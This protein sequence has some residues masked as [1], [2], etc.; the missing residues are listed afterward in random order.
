MAKNIVICV[1]GTNGTFGSRNTNVVRLYSLLAQD[2][3][4]QVCFYDPGI[5]TMAAPGALTQFTQQLTKLLG[6]AIAYGVTDRIADAYRHLMECYEPGDRVYLFGFSRGAYIVRALAG[7]LHMCGLLR[8]ANGTLVQSAIDLFSKHDDETFRVAKEFRATFCRECPVHFVGVWDTVSSVGWIYDPISFPYTANNPSVAIGRHAISIDERRCYFR[9]NLWGPASEGQD[10]K[11]SWFAGVHSDIG[12]GYPANE[13][14]LANV[15]LRWMMDEAKAA[16]LLFEPVR[17]A[18][19][20]E[21][22]NRPDPLG[23]LHDSLRGFWWI[24]EFWPKRY[25][26]TTQHPPVVRYEIP[27]GRGRWIP[28]DARIH[29]SVDE[30]RAKRELR[31]DPKNLPP[32]S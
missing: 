28:P 29:P 18:A 25:T 24:L 15:T 30:R 21:A 16:G 17:M 26:D 5:G 7:L 32:R 13:S 31:Y 23:R 8:P 3:E 19:L 1:D 6:A 27:A 9:Q 11:Q 10:L 22:N 4:R 14:G 2:P 20:D 12:G